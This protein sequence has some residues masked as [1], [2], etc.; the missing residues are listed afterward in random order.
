MGLLKIKIKPILYFFPSKVPYYTYKYIKKEIFMK[1]L[2]KGTVLF[3]ATIASEVSYTAIFI[4]NGDTQYTI[5]FALEYPK[6][7]E[8]IPRLEKQKI[9]KDLEPGDYIQIERDP[10]YMGW[11]NFKGQMVVETVSQYF[12][13]R[14]LM[15]R[16]QNIENATIVLNISGTTT[17][18]FSVPEEFKWTTECMKVAKEKCMK[19]AKEQGRKNRQ[20]NAAATGVPLRRKGG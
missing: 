19:I 8:Y 4:E 13:L 7:K 11:Y 17:I 16:H 5:R 14:N 18:K 1:N 20:R 9:K 15:K 12:E 2:F 10:S 3:L 6:E